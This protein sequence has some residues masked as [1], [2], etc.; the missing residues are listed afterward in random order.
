MLKLYEINGL[1][2]EDAG[3]LL[4][5][6]FSSRDKRAKKRADVGMQTVGCI[7]MFNFCG[8]SLWG[9]PMTANLS[10]T[11]ALCKINYCLD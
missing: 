7:K 4:S 2:M 5:R 1:V 3:N 8:F 6:L 11:V 9:F 10:Q